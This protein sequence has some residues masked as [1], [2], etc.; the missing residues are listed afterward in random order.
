MNNEL[1]KEYDVLDK[2]SHLISEAMAAIED[3]DP[4]AENRALYNIHEKIGK[5][6]EKIIAR[7]QF[8]ENEIEVAN[9]Q[10]L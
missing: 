9:S 4:N 8:I 3:F 1:H 6:M 7:E 5:S 2:V 10:A